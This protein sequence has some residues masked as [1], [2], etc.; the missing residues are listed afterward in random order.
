VANGRSPHPSGDVPRAVANVVFQPKS[1]VALSSERGERLQPPRRFASRSGFTSAMAMAPPTS[2]MAPHMKKPASP[3]PRRGT[4]R[5]RRHRE[6][7][8]RC[9]P[10]RR[11]YPYRSAHNRRPVGGYSETFGR[12]R[13]Q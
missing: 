11:R 9:R 1:M 4:R 12:H 7:C 10:A 13:P 5:L 3:P 8:P 2:I 6:P